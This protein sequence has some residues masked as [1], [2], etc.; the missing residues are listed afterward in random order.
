MMGVKWEAYSRETIEVV[1]MDFVMKC[2]I[3]ACWSLK[4]C[5]SSNTREKELTSKDCLGL[6]G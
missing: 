5:K 6:K 3:F 1:L 4:I 2:D